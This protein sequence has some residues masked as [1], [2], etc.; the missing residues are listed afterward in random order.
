MQIRFI[1]SRQIRRRN[2]TIRW[3]AGEIYPYDADMEPMIAA[4]HAERI[5][6]VGDIAVASSSK[7]ATE[8]RQKA[9]V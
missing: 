8:R 9:L 5:P 7:P 6:E 2:Q 3:A 4:G 1:E